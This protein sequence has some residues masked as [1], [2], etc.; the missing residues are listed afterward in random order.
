M[1]K[2]INIVPYNSN[3]PKM[4]QAISKQLKDIKSLNNNDKKILIGKINEWTNFHSLML[5]LE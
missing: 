5:I 4:F 2:K 3:W 1:K